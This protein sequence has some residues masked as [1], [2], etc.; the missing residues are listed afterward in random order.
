[1]TNQI[2]GKDDEVI[3]KRDRLTIKNDTHIDY[4][5]MDL[6][7]VTFRLIW[8]RDVDG[9]HRETPKLEP[10]TSDWFNSRGIGNGDNERHFDIEVR[11]FLE[12]GAADVLIGKFTHTV[13]NPP[14]SN[15][16]NEET[17]LRVNINATEG[18]LLFRYFR[19]Y[20][21][22]DDLT[23]VIGYLRPHFE[24]P[25]TLSADIEQPKLQDIS[26]DSL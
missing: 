21:H 24:H 9:D 7:G 23:E 20:N 22:T 4:A 19:P 17:Q 25:A 1:M 11:A 10:N 14:G 3:T 15:G 6:P 26:D 5:I 13:I 18:P 16:E 12:E 2:Y 8:S